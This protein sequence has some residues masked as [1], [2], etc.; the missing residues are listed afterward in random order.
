MKNDPFDST[1]QN[2][3]E[4]DYSTSGIFRKKTDAGDLHMFFSPFMVP[5]NLTD[6][7][8]SFCLELHGRRK[9]ISERLSN[10][11][12][13]EIK[14]GLQKRLENDYL[15]LEKERETLSL[16]FGEHAFCLAAEEIA[17]LYSCLR[18]AMDWPIPLPRELTE[19]PMTREKFTSGVKT[20]IDRMD[21]LDQGMC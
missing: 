2:A 7:E 6:G 3:R 20:L 18:V 15:A 5:A 9:K 12:K 4:Q 17:N 21:K 14:T 1:S 13:A 19:S 8:V 10:K 11:K 16:F